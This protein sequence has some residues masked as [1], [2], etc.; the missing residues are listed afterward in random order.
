MLQLLNNEISP[1]RVYL[2]P[3]P[4]GQECSKGKELDRCCGDTGFRRVAGP[5]I[6][7]LY[8]HRERATRNFLFMRYNSHN[9]KESK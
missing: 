8:I 6:L 2:T 3:N 7:G 5:S 1:P 4:P 9:E